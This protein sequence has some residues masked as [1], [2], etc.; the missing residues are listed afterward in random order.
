MMAIRV[1]VVPMRG[2]KKIGDGL[3]LFQG[4]QVVCKHVE[5]DVRMLI[6]DAA[7]CGSPQGDGCYLRLGLK[8]P[9]NTLRKRGV[10]C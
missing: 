10:C 1:E 9:G 4:H 8:L 3:P 5:I 2:T 6:F 7:G